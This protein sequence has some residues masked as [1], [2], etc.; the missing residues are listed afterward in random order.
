M[1]VISGASGPRSASAG[2][3]GVLSRTARNATTAA[4][5][6]ATPVTITVITRI[7]E[8]RGVRREV[9]GFDRPDLDTEPTEGQCSAKASAERPAEAFAL[10]YYQSNFAPNRQSRGGTIVVGFRNVPPEPQLMLAAGFAFV[11]L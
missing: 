6:S 7:G 3:A 1:S 10:L 2:G 5:N 9:C 8:R 11:R 4:D